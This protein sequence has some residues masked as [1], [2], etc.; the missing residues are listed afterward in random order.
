MKITS[1]RVK[2]PKITLPAPSTPD[3]HKEKRKYIR[4]YHIEK[5][6]GNNG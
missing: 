5:K 3:V 4:T 1:K 2:I 6:S